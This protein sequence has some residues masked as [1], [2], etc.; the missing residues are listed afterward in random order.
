MTTDL[1]E[2][3]VLLLS[4]VPLGPAAPRTCQVCGFASGAFDECGLCFDVADRA[5]ARSQDI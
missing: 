3:P 2:H 4:P 5:F 1:L